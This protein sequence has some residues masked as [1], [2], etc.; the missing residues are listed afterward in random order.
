MAEPNHVCNV[1]RG[2]NQSKTSYLFN[3]LF[4]AAVTSHWLCLAV[5]MSGDVARIDGG[6]MWVSGDAVF[7]YRSEDVKEPRKL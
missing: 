1:N 7:L 4:S 5:D 2:L 6:V 3:T